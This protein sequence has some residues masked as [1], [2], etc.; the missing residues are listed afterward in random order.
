MAGDFGIVDYN[1]HTFPDLSL[2]NAV[3]I[4]KQN[5][6]DVD[7]ID[8]NAE[9]KYPDAIVK[10]I[11]PKN[12]DRIILK[13]AS[14]TLKLD[15]EFARCLKKLFPN[16]TIV[17]TGRTA[18]LLK[19]WID[20]FV[21]EF[22]EISIINIEDY[23]NQL[24]QETNQRLVL[25]DLPSPDYSLSPYRQY[26][27]SNGELRVTLYTSRGCVIKCGYCP[28]AVLY[29]DFEERSLDK[30]GDDIEGILSLGIRKIQFRD[31]YFSCKKERTLA[32][33]N[34][35]IKRKLKFSWVCE[36][37]VDQLDKETLEVMIDSGMEMICLGIETPSKAIHRMYQRPF[38]DI[39]KLKEL[40][41]FVN[42][43]GIK[44]LG[45]Y[46][47]GFSSESWQDMM[48]T[49]NLASELGTTYANFNIWTP[50]IGTKSGSQFIP[51]DEIN[52][53]IF[54][55]FKNFIHYKYLNGMDSNKLEFVTRLLNSNY[56]LQMNGLQGAY[57]DYYLQESHKKRILDGFQQ[58]KAFFRT[59][60]GD[61]KF[62][63]NLNLN[64]G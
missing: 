31:Q 56:I 7:F 30:L 41:Q 16:S 47:I 44:T 51:Q 25:D 24:T 37:K 12:Y 19:N 62:I 3:S 40:I 38:S 50:Y 29:N 6:F 15:I 59:I 28:Y 1:N 8:A 64:D 23:V 45:F 13:V 20:Q 4:L 42:E 43:K 17:I 46:I 14:A 48:E 39:K 33:C 36:T 35:I 54:P 34:M 55:L 18:V 21:K 63:T 57:D 53:D 49:Y 2:I 60:L 10:N 11:P 52:I 27:N 9:K 61:T 5:N 32:I 22:D 26:R 58:S